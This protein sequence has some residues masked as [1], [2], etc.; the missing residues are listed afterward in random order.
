MRPIP[1]VDATRPY[2]AYRTTR[3][4]RGGRW[5]AAARP[6]ERRRQE[7]TV[8]D[9]S[10]DIVSKVDHQEID[11]AINQAGKEVSTRYDFRDVGASVAWSG[12]DV[13]LKANSE[14]RVKATLDV[15]QEKCVKRGISLKALEHGDPVASGKE[16]RLAVKIQQGIADDKAKAIA[17]KIRAD[18]PKGVQAQIQGDQLRV[19]GKKR[20]DLQRVI[21][22]LK[23]ED[24][25]LPLQFVNYR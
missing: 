3:A 20:D 15:L 4:P 17:K 22:L 12:E 19:T 8:A 11:N 21:Q 2:A 25:G 24:F 23:S 10:F 5:R 9:P 13:L 7:E 6:P 1:G 18:G 16:F 14:E